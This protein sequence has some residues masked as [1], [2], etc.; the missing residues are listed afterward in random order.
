MIRSLNPKEYGSYM[1]DAVA[2]YKLV[3]FL[4]GDLVMHLEILKEH[5]QLP[6]VVV[7][8]NR[9]HYEL[10]EVLSLTLKGMYQNETGLKYEKLINLYGN[11]F[12]D[13]ERNSIQC[14]LLDKY[15]LLLTNDD[16][17]RKK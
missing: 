1:N 9:I 14:L 2:L 6:D 7:A 10:E 4:S 12:T 13:D 16:L 15:N 3:K 17:E 11:D 8:L 5:Y